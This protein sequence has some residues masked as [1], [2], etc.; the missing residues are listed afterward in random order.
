M[1]GFAVVGCA[2]VGCAV[3]GRAV[4]GCAVGEPVLSC[5]VGLI[6][7]GCAV[8]G[9]AVGDCTVGAAEGAREA[10][11]GLAVGMLGAVRTERLNECDPA[12]ANV[13][14]ASLFELSHL[15]A[16]SSLLEGAGQT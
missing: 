11:V 5:G 8:V 16:M 3:V 6:A 15:I 9:R 10:E 7:E 14:T 1:L 12:S 13:R 2:V 4:V